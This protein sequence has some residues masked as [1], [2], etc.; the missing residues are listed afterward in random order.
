MS[1]NDEQELRKIIE[2]LQEKI[3]KNEQRIQQL[4]EALTF[5]EE[6]KERIKKIREGMNKKIKMLGKNEK[7]VS[8]IFD[9]IETNLKDPDA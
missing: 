8:Q 1:N 5:T 3:E 6:E 4:E 9:S 7:K 2:Q